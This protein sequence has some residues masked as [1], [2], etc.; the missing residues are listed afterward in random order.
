M[1]EG[2][3]ARH[4]KVLRPWCEGLHTT[5]VWVLMKC[6]WEYFCNI[7]EGTE[8][9]YV[10]VIKPCCEGLYT[11]TPY[12]YLWNMCE[13]ICTTYVRVFR[14]WCVGIYTITIWVPMQHMWGYL[15]NICEGT[16]TIMWGYLYNNFKGTY[17]KYV[18]VFKQHMW[19]DSDHAW[20]EGHYDT[21]T[22]ARLSTRVCNIYIYTCYVVE[23]IS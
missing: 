15:H 16:E 11:P 22:I 6:M 1:C 8:T 9:P 3:C 20:C 12:R 10:K 19:R 5:I 18:R 23:L 4:V 14:T 13:G 7:C 17:A 2:T 21:T